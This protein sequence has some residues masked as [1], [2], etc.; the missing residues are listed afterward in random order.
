M[1][2]KRCSIFFSSKR[3]FILQT[4]YSAYFYPFTPF[5]IFAYSPYSSA[6]QGE[7]PPCIAKYRARHPY[8]WCS[9]S[10]CI[11]LTNCMPGA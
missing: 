3:F 9:T 5:T 2:K 1:L 8:A 11:L 7:D 4:A 10:V 6:I